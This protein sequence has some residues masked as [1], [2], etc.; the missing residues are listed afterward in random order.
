MIL[1]KQFEK[2]SVEL[3]KYMSDFLEEKVNE[4]S[5]IMKDKIGQFINRRI[6]SFYNTPSHNITLF[7]SDGESILKSAE[8]AFTKKNWTNL[9][10]EHYFSL[11]QTNKRCFRINMK[12]SS[13]FF[14]EKC[15]VVTG[16]PYLYA[17]SDNS[18]L[19]FSI[20]PHSLRS[21]ML[22]TIKHFQ[23]NHYENLEHGLSM[24]RVHPQF[25][26]SNCTDFENVCEEEY[27]Q[28]HDKKK[29]LE[30]I[31]EEHEK[32]LD[33]KKKWLFV[34]EKMAQM[35][36]DLENFEKFRKELNEYL[37]DVSL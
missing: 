36:V 1:T 7:D 22:R 2:E 3:K 15:V 6:L 10:Q 4:F 5:E 11:K 32:L 31:E 27:R 18:G 23:L 9:L 30:K 29:E 16:T 35:N 12:E 8:E 34:K 20:F 17:F 37:E 25:F 28:I 13:Y 33:E 24:Y 21:D 19:R 14:F 26:H